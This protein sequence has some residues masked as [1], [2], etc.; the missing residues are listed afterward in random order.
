M[1]DASCQGGHLQAL[2]ANDS[3]GEIILCGAKPSSSGTGSPVSQHR[4]SNKHTTVYIGRMSESNEP[5]HNG[6]QAFFLCLVQSSLLFFS[7]SFLLLFAAH[8]QTQSLQSERERFCACRRDKST[9]VVSGGF[10]F[11]FA[12]R[13]LPQLFLA[14][15]Q[16][17]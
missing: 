12:N 10:Y 8:G 13:H 7:L 6:T 2:D 4:V 11:P 14:R 15:E 16:L 1:F 17:R 5:L 9:A 3:G